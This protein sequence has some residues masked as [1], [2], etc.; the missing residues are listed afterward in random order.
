MEAYIGQVCCFAFN[1]AP[2]NWAVCNGAL[3]SIN[4]NQ[5]LFVLL[6]TTYG[7]DGKST[8]G[9]PNMPAGAAGA[10]YICTSGAYP[11]RP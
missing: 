9:L 11:Q 10:Y 4:A 5:V 6:G 8:F 1:Y 7:G 3:L 2:A